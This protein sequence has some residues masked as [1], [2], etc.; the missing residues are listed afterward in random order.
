MLLVLSVASALV[1]LATAQT[2][3][4]TVSQSMPPTATAAFN[5]ANV[6]SNDACEYLHPSHSCL[7]LTSHPSI[8]LWCHAQLNTCPQICGGAAS[9]NT[10]DKVGQHLIQPCHVLLYDLAAGMNLFDAHIAL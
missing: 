5:P 4:T 10:C 7:E 1:A 8:V 9:T 3:S 6:S 2:A